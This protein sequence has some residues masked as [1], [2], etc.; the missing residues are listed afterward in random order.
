MYP[1]NTCKSHA[2]RSMSVFFV[3]RIGFLVGRDQCEVKEEVLRI[4]LILQSQGTKGVYC[5][6][7][8]RSLHNREVGAR[9]FSLF[10][11]S[12]STS[13]SGPCR[14]KNRYETW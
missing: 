5:I 11:Q 3:L 14:I 6:L 7:I 10:D 12:P 13:F 8:G 2:R 9:I 4:A 1:C